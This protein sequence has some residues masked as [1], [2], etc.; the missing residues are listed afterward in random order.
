MKGK[1]WIFAK[2]ETDSLQWQDIMVNDN[3]EWQVN[4]DLYTR[5]IS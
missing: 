3:G 1:N 4:F 5:R 2:I